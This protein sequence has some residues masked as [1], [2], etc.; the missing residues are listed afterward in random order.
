MA[1]NVNLV[2]DEQASPEVKA[3]FTKIKEQFGDVPPTMRAMANYPEYLG[4]LL[5][6]MNLVLGA[7]KLDSKT[8]M[9][10]ALTIS[11]LN[12]CD[13][14][15]DMYTSKLKQMGTTDQE[16]VEL[17]AVIDLVGGMNHFNNGIGIH[18]QK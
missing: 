2:S 1:V 3:M 14:C 16:L 18:P 15:I 5:Q 9:L 7:G 12:N 11:T 8:K 6:K 17:M 13:T 4:M 10:I